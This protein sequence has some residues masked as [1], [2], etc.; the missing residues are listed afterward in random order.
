MDFDLI[1]EYAWDAGFTLTVLVL[2]YGVLYGVDH[3]TKQL[4]H[5][6][7]KLNLR[8]VKVFGL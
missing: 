3:L 2:I 5:R 7:L 6:L 8:N 4:K 1:R